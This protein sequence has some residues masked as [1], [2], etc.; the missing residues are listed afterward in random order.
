[1][2]WTYAILLVFML[3]SISL[4][5]TFVFSRFTERKQV[6]TISS[7]A[8]TIEFW[9]ATLQVEQTDSELMGEIYHVRYYSGNPRGQGF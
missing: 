9:T 1:M 4:S 8:H 5:M 6:E 7:V 3:S 2:F